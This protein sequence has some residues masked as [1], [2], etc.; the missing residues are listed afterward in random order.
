MDIHEYQAKDILARFG[1]PVPRGR[2]FWPNRQATAPR[3]GRQC[4]SSRP[5]SIPAGVARQAG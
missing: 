4:G 5:R 3:T 1:V 2:P